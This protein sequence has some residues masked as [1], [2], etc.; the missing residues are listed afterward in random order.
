M[1]HLLYYYYHC[2]RMYRRKTFKGKWQNALDQHIILLTLFVF[3]FFSRTYEHTQLWFIYWLV[4]YLKVHRPS[5]NAFYIFVVSFIAAHI[6]IV[7]CYWLWC[8]THFILPY[9][10][11]TTHNYFVWNHIFIMVKCPFSWLISCITTT[12]TCLIIS[13]EFNGLISINKCG[14]FYINIV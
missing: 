5:L 9:H 1:S 6:Y 11:N 3:F 14:I 13:D 4:V 2:T 7:Q 8:I 12:K 10:T